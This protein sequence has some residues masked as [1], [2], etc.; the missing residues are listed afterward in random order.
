MALFCLAKLL[1]AKWT[2]GHEWPWKRNLLIQECSRPLGSISMIS[3]DCRSTT[4]YRQWGKTL[5]FEI[6]GKAKR[7]VVETGVDS[8]ENAP[9]TLLKTSSLDLAPLSL[10]KSPENWDVSS[11]QFFLHESVNCTTE[12]LIYEQNSDK[13]KKIYKSFCGSLWNEF[14]LIW[15]NFFWL[16]KI[17]K[18]LIM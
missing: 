13:M 15:M 8:E 17:K 7:N 4:F 9:F 18:R 14:I 5:L 12:H 16:E 10:R 6:G 1:L 11:G 2:R 3:T